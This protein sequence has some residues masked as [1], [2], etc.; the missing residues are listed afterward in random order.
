M[1]TGAV[2]RSRETS[3]AERDPLAPEG[4]VGMRKMGI[5]VDPDLL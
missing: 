5:G 2:I 4:Y 1:T 3:G